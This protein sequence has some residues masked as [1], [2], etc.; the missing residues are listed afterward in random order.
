MTYG[1]TLSADIAV[2]RRQCWPVSRQLSSTEFSAIKHCIAMF[3]SF[4][5]RQCWPVCRGSQQCRPIN[6]SFNFILLVIFCRFSQQC[7]GI[8]SSNFPR[9]SL[10]V[11]LSNLP[12]QHHWFLLCRFFSAGKR[13]N[14]GSNSHF[15]TEILRFFIFVLNKNTT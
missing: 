13:V 1:P 12:I 7:Y 15:L 11:V 10:D 14:D 9:L 4:D 3:F 8:L 5:G 2:R 6:F